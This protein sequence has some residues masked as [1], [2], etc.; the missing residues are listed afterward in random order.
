[1]MFEHHYSHILMRK[2]AHRI[3]GD[4]KRHL[5]DKF[6]LN[7]DRTYADGNKRVNAETALQQV[8]GNYGGG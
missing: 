4:A 6:G 2:F 8:D 1:M 7:Q 5:Q 3:A